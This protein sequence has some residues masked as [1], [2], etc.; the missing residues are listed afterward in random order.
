MR[1]E[2]EIEIGDETVVLTAGDEDELDEM[3][4]DLLDVDGEP[5]SPPNVPDSSA[6]VAA[7]GR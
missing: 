3:I 1:F 7:N 4:D 2:A 5:I 6:T